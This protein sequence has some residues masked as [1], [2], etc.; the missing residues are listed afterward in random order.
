[1]LPKAGGVATGDATDGRRSCYWSQVTPLLLTL[2]D[3]ATDG[4]R[5]C[6]KA[7]QVVMLPDTRWRR[8]CCRAAVLPDLKGTTMVLPD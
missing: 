4:G 2:P 5:S 1:L 8:W 3:D 7:M 6:C